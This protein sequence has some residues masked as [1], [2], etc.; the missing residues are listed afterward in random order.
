MPRGLEIPGEK[1]ALAVGMWK[2]GVKQ[3]II[4]K[5]LGL[6]PSTLCRI[7]KRFKARNTVKNNPRSGRPPATTRLERCRMVSWAKQHH[8]QPYKWVM[9]RYCIG[10][11]K[12]TFVRVLRRAGLQR[13][14]AQLAPRLTDKHKEKRREWA[15]Y[16]VGIDWRRV[17]FTDE[18]SFKA[19]ILGST[20]PK[21]TRK[22]GARERHLLRNMATKWKSRP[23]QLMVWGAIAIGHKSPLVRMQYRAGESVNGA[24]YSD[25]II[26]DNLAPFLLQVEQ[27]LPPSLLPALACEDNAKPHSCRV[28]AE[29]RDTIGMVP[30]HHPPQSPD[31]NPIEEVWL[32]MKQRM[33]SQKG[34]NLT[35]NELWELVQ[36]YWDEVPQPWIDQKIRSMDSR[37]SAVAKQKG[38]I[39]SKMDIRATVPSIEEE[40]SL[41]SVS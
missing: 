10:V 32:Y 20:K 39:I 28:S 17:V 9:A 18:S 4:A 21:V 7:I 2:G 11:S 24:M 35:L 25:L 29:M 31:L 34:R 5:E 33:A 15:A 23:Q 26:H 14:T 8:W 6:Q 41:T 40:S 37:R 27:A 30:Y 12:T 16:A 19:D 22:R 3:V 38:G 13:Y 36:E 1:R